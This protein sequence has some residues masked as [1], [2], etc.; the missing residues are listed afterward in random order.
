MIVG[1]PK[2]TERHEWRVAMTPAGAGSLTAAGHTVLVENDAGVGAGL[3]DGEYAEAGA[4]LWKTKADLYAQADMIVKVQP[5][6]PQEYRLL[7]EGQILFAHLYAA[8][9]PERTRAL[10]DAKVIGI[11]CEAV[12]LDDGA[13]PLLACMDE[14]AGRLAVQWGA[15]WLQADKGGRGVLLA[16]APGTTPAE[17]VVIG[18]AAAGAAAAAS[19]MGARVTLLDSDLEGSRRRTTALPDSVA[20]LPAHD[21]SIERAVVAA[22]LVVAALFGPGQKTGFVVTKAMMARMRRGSVVVDL[23]VDRGGCVEGTIPAPLD[24]PTV[25][26]DGVTLVCPIDIV[27][28]AAHTATQASA[29]VA[30]PYVAALADCGWEG[31]LQAD[32]ALA[33]GLIA[34]RGGL[35]SEDVARGLG[36]RYEPCDI[37]DLRQTGAR[38]AE[39]L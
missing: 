15:Q 2:E 35:V 18:G 13:R 23:A 28:A 25:H 19:A 16:G 22:D 36:V 27:R 11:A 17:V 10:L 20:V 38:S 34:L 6:S 8:A 21:A 32:R 7:R 33:R 3:S 14:V 30:F 24:R 29:A 12:R 39:D 1:V 9:C 37:S 31:A 26:L 4:V 5:P